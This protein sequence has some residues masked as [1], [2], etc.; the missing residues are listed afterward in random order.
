M[1]NIIT[2]KQAI[3]KITKKYLWEEKIQQKIIRINNK[4]YYTI[5]NTTYE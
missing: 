3:D 5:N 1:F 4:W 2:R